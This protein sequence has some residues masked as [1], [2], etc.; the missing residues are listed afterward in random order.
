LM[1]T[2]LPIT[3]PA[4]GAGEGLLAGIQIAVN[5]VNEAGGIDGRTIELIPLDDGF[6]P[7]RTVSNMR[8][9]IEEE[10]VYA[11]PSP[12]GSQGIPGAWEFV[13]QAGT[14]VWGPVSPPDPQLQPAY[15]LGPGRGEQM[16][17]CADYAAEQ[18]LTRVGLIGQDN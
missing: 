17:I 18:G 10:G 7:A 14:I 11:M 3:G 15:I 12:A 6:D 16:R 8:R 1:G 13:D 4:A 9:L 5:E 2:T